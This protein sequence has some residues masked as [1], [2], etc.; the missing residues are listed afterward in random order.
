MCELLPRDLVC[1]D[2]IPR[3]LSNN[4]TRHYMFQPRAKGG[5]LKWF[6]I[7]GENRRFLWAD[8]EIEGDTIVVHSDAVKYPVAVRYAW[9]DD[10]L[11]CNLYNRDGLPA[12]PFRTDDWNE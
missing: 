8:A 10:P 6:A 7:A 3:L 2:P 12:S 1:C 9:W 11:G 5:P 4:R